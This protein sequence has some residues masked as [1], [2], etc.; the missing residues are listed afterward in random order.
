MCENSSSTI[1]CLLRGLLFILAFFLLVGAGFVGYHVKK[2]LDSVIY[3]TPRGHVGN[4]NPGDLGLSYKAVE[5]TAGE[6]LKVKGWFIDGRKEKC[7]IFA[8]GKGRTRWDFLDLAPPLNKAGFDLFLFDPRGTGKSEGNK[9]GFGYM[10][11]RD[12]LD[13]IKFLEKVF[14]VVKFGL[15]GG[16]TGATASLM[17]ALEHHDIHAVV[18]D[19]PFCNIKLA[20]ETFGDYN[21]WPFFKLIFP[22]Y[23]F[24]ANKMIGANVAELTN[25]RERIRKLRVPVY[26]IHGLADEIICPKN[27]EILFANKPGEK[28]I[29]TPGGVGHVRSF[30]VFREAYLDKITIFFEANL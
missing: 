12:I 26:F 16:S 6:G 4:R 3:S 19:S 9:W 5:F 17:A 30:V 20:S 15:L 28:Y 21:N 24:G 13:A 8:P 29:W 23:M 18:A 14:G 1:K 7:I 27:T 11:S 25:L 2:D 22:L 10:E